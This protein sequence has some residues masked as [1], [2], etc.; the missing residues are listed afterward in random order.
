MVKF[1]RKTGTLDITEYS[2]LEEARLY[3]E[4]SLT[5]LRS[6]GYRITMPRVQ[7]IRALADTQKALSPYAIHEKIVGANGKIDVVSVYRIVSTL[8]EIG[9]VYHVGVV[10]GY[11][12]ARKMDGQSHRSE[13]IACEACQTVQELT[14]PDGI[15]DSIEH[16]AKQS[17][18][19]L[20]SVKVEL[21]ARQCPQ[22]KGNK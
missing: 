9:L 2:T 14:M 12:P 15:V 21:M 18:F 4:Y 11:F 6:R 20:T 13:L 17:G 1:Q 22:C 3:E 10:D 8:Q 16:Q 5:E 7:V 19:V